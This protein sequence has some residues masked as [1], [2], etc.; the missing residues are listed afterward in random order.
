MTPKLALGYLM[1]AT[2]V[3]VPIAGY[4]GTFDSWSGQP[5]ADLPLLA[6]LISVW[7]LVSAFGLWFWMLA[8]FFRGRSLKHRVVIGFCLVFLSCLAAVLY[9]VL[10]YARAPKQGSSSAQAT[11]AT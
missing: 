2:I 8:D 11:S 4:A 5:W 9:F 1:V 3:A 6:K 10:V 7:V